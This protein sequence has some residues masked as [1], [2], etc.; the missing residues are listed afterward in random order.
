MTDT[1]K[2]KPTK[3]KDVKV[4]DEI[5]T[6][7]TAIET[8]PSHCDCDPCCARIET[9]DEPIVGGADEEVLVRVED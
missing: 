4:G 2:V 1:I 3:L 7:V 9:G 6:W 8:E 5:V